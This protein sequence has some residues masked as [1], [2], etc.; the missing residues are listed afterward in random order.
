MS[1]CTTST[2]FA[3]LDFTSETKC[4]TYLHASQSIHCLFGTKRSFMSFL[5]KTNI[6]G[7]SSTHSTN[8]RSCWTFLCTNYSVYLLWSFTSKNLMW[9]LYCCDSI[10]VSVLY[11]FCWIVDSSCSKLWN[12][13]TWTVLNPDRHDMLVGSGHRTDNWGCCCMKQYA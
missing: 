11:L 1:I 3:W 5:L 2:G 6:G 13:F 10:F 7:T 4:F 8:D 12:L 9:L